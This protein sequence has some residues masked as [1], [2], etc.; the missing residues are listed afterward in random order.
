MDPVRLYDTLSRENR[1]LPAG[2]SD[3]FRMYVCGPT[4]YGPAHIGNFLT[5]N[6]FDTLYRLLKV[7]GYDPL[8]VRNIT[9]VD[10][11]TIKGAVEAGTSLEDF[12]GKWTRRFHDD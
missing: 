10:D 9:D 8:Y 2:R 5:F 3:R 7:A 1:A 12:T 11:K 6:R 4:V